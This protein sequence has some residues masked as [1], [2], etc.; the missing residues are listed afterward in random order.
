MPSEFDSVVCGPRGPAP[1]S[2]HHGTITSSWQALC[3]SIIAV[4]LDT[5]KQCKFIHS[6]SFSHRLAATQHVF[7]VNLSTPPAMWPPSDGPLRYCHCTVATAGLNPSTGSWNIPT[8]GQL[9]KNEI[10]RMPASVQ[11][12]LPRLVVNRITYK[13]SYSCNCW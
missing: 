4:T 6:S 2:C 13:P 9:S 8:R 1:R 5:V 12:Q 11:S 10:Q 3:H 7:A